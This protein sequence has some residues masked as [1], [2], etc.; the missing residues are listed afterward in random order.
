MRAAVEQHALSESMTV[1]GR[2]GTV[3]EVA[4]A[5]RSPRSH[6][7]ASSCGTDLLMAR[8]L[9]PAMSLTDPEKS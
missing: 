4:A 9:R 1:L 2:M 8:R 7:A 6:E 5:G 3:E